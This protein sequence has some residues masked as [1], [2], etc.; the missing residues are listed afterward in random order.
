MVH[1]RRLQLA[2]GAALIALA[3]IPI[4]R[5]AGPSI[6]LKLTGGTGTRR[7]DCAGKKPD[8]YA[9]VKRGSKVRL[10]GLVRPVPAAPRWHVTITVSRCTN[11]HF[12]PSWSRV[13]RGRPNGS[14]ETVFA[15]RTPGLY[16]ARAVS[17]DGKPRKQ[18]FIVIAA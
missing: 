16:M 2:L 13:V 9:V 3:G 18:R 17:G 7:I 6:M 14:F 1:R 12:H 15:A 4:A 8:P 10:T 5:A 11:Q